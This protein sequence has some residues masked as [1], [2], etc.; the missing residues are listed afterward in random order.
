MDSTQA[1]YSKRLGKLVGGVFFTC[2]SFGSQFEFNFFF[3]T[4]SSNSQMFASQFSPWVCMAIFSNNSHFG[5]IFSRIHIFRHHFNSHYITPWNKWLLFIFPWR[6]RTI[7]KSWNFFWFFQIGV[8]THAA[9][10]YKW[11]FW[12]FL[13]IFETIFTPNIQQMDS[14]NCSNFVFI[15]HKVTFHPKLHAPLERPTF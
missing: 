12:D 9:F 2:P 14:L 3:P 7:L 6:L 13:N 15:L 11:S 1:L 5:T 8:P 10:I 4:W